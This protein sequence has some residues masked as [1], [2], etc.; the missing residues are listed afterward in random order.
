MTHLTISEV[1]DMAGYYIVILEHSFYSIEQYV[2]ARHL[3]SL[4]CRSFNAY[5]KWVY[6]FFI[7]IVVLFFF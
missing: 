7:K 3:K 4:N 6:F 5:K 2:S 1:N